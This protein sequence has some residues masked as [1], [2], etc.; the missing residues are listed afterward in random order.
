[1]CCYQKLLESLAWRT[2]TPWHPESNVS[3]TASLPEGHFE[4][5]WKGHG[6]TGV[7]QDSFPP[8]D[9]IIHQSLF[10][11]RTAHRLAGFSRLPPFSWR[12]ARVKG[13]HYGTLW[14]LRIHTQ[15]LMLLQSVPHPLDHLP[16]PR[17][18]MRIETLFSSS[19]MTMVSHDRSVLSSSADSSPT[20]KKYPS[21]KTSGALIELLG[22]HICSTQKTVLLRNSQDWRLN[23]RSMFAFPFLLIAFRCLSWQSLGALCLN[24]CFYKMLPGV[25]SSSLCPRP[26]HLPPCTFC[27]YCLLLVL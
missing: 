10:C 4:R 7:A 18:S 24:H 25:S 16:S 21:N 5:R 2:E 27:A 13:T 23:L 1:M 3:D 15:D 9:S 6:D 11:R 20:K 12:N 22:L 8:G 19:R 17:L 26:L 14:V